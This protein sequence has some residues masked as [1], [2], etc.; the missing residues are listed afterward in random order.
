MSESLVFH[1][2][3]RDLR[4]FTADIEKR[5]LRWLAA[6]MP[7]GVNSDH[8]TGLGFAAMLAGG[9]AYAISGT[10]LGWLHVVNL[11]LLANWFGDSLDG[12]LARY[13]NRQRPRYGFY[14]DHLVDAL[15]FLALLTGLALS[16]HLSVA[17]AVGLVVAYYLVSIHVY[18]STY[19]L[20]VFRIAYGRVGGTELRILL[21]ATNL[22]VLR[23]PTLQLAGFE[24]RLF[25]L[26]GSLALAG[27]VAT[28]LT[29][30]LS[31]VRRLYEMERI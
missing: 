31:S 2:A 8:L 14:V 3:Q 20:G 5:V 22:A 13:R 27:L 21:A 25:D 28:L 18:L 1:E 16:G 26:C 9:A 11:L 23:W 19:A 15:G 12:T 30:T 4:S 24:V 29:A 10:N 6:R 17:V 7:A